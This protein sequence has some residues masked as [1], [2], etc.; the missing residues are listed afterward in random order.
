MAGLHRVPPLRRMAGNE[1][2]HR[3]GK[4]YEN[5]NKTHVCIVAC[6]MMEPA[7]PGPPTPVGQRNNP[8]GGHSAVKS[9]SESIMRPAVTKVSPRGRSM[10]YNAA[11]DTLP[12]YIYATGICRIMGHV[13]KEENQ[14]AES[15]QAHP[16][17]DRGHRTCGRCRQRMRHRL[18]TGDRLPRRLSTASSRKSSRDHIREHMVDPRDS[19]DSPQVAAAEDLIEIVHQYLKK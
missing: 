11:Q 1:P 10:L 15:H 19:R 16:R 7:N 4:S 8:P 9:S 2:P 5:H 3:D 13:A 17:S 18:A 12:P 14:A 6:C